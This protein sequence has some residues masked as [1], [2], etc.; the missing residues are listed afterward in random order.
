MSDIINFSK[1][2]KK[3]KVGNLYLIDCRYGLWGVSGCDQDKVMAEAFH[4]WGQYADDGE[5]S[6][7]I[8]GKTAI[9]TLLDN[10]NNT[11]EV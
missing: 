11:N 5:Y 3:Y 9:E 8:G 2:V 6:S 7:I 1:C 4:Y 10:L